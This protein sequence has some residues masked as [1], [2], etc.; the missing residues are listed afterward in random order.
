MT[1]SSV[2]DLDMAIVTCVVDVALSVSVCWQRIRN[3]AN[4]GKFLDVPS[5]LV[6]GSGDIGS[7]RQIGDAILEALVGR[8]DASYTYVQTK[9]PMAAY[10]YHGCVALTG[11]G[12]ES[13]TL[14]YTITFNQAMM[15]AE[16]RSNEHTRI[17]GRFQGAVEAMKRVAELGEVA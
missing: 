9:G 1:E 13:C 11:T 8:S 14:T 16:R 4:A 17:S 10:L 2:P 5:K 15:D 7:I 3:F 12:A 6:S